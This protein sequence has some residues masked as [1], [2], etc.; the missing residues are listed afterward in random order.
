VRN[1]AVLFL[2]V[3]TAGAQPQRTVSD[4]GWL[5]GNWEL[6]KG[7]RRTDEVWLAPAG[8]KMFSVSRT[9]R[10][11]KAVEHEFVTLEQDSTGTI[12]YRA[13][14]SG[15]KG[16]SFPLT[17]FEHWSAVFEDTLHDFPQRI[18]YRRI[19]DDSLTARIEG[20]INGALRGIDFRYRKIKN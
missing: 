16:A 2:I 12:Y 6:I 1:A 20:R 4:L 5:T 10:S 3:V 19:S 9:V 15:Q 14:P 11:G 8:N 13:Q 18:I 17:V 7:E